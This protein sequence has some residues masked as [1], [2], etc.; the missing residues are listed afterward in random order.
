VKLPLLFIFTVSGVSYAQTALYD[1]VPTNP[2]GPNPVISVPQNKTAIA[3]Y[4]V[5][6]SGKSTT[7]NATINGAGVTQDYTS[8]T[9]DTYPVCSPK[10]FSL[11]QNKICILKLKI[12]GSG[13][14]S[15]TSTIQPIICN[16]SKICFKTSLNNILTIKRT[17]KVYS[18][19]GTIS[20]HT[21]DLVLQNN[22]KDDLTITKTMTQFTFSN[23]FVQGSAY[24][25]KIKTPPTG[26]TCTLKN[27]TGSFGASDI[28]NINVTCTNT[29][30]NQESS[31]IR[32]STPTE[33]NRFISVPNQQLILDIGNDSG[34]LK[35]A[36]NIRVTDKTNCPN[37][38]ADSSSCANLR[39]GQSCSLKLSSTT[40]YSPCTITIQGDNTNALRTTI[41]FKYQDGWVFTSDGVKGKIASEV[42]HEF[43]SS[44]VF[45]S[46][47]PV[48]GA[49]SND[50]GKE[51]TDAILADASCT[52]SLMNCA[53]N[54]CRSLG[55]DWYLPAID[56]LN[57]I[58]NQ[59][60]NK[61]TN[62]Y[63]GPFG[64]P[65]GEYYWSSTQ[66]PTETWGTLTAWARDFKG[67]YPPNYSAKNEIL[68]IRC[69]K[70]F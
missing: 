14:L 51:N 29:V 3:E 69:I 56:E 58:Y 68:K 44:W 22:G 59:L 61:T 6:N 31:S 26:Q 70:S 65:Y 34:S 42:Q 62:E 37:I 60:K 10:Q 25:V 38:V 11:G 39:I 48:P 30:P 52:R 13:L 19:G 17:E 43:Y 46:G 54:L 18:L 50:N 47:D 2:P 16:S 64:G 33:E 1:A 21:G 23:N 5:T 8:S 41:A 27:F 49:F 32:I 63:A 4:T 35:D 28:S 20:G 15:D 55:P 45:A 40:P 57:L 24:D 9:Q 7:L 36:S 67:P 66:L 53:A 12:V